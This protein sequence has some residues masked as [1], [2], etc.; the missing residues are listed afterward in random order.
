MTNWQ[1]LGATTLAVIS[2]VVAVLWPGHTVPVTVQDALVAVAGLLVALHVHVPKFL[3]QWA[4]NNTSTDASGLSP[5]ERIL[6]S[7]VRQARATGKS[8]G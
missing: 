1:S 4:V 3:T 5:T 2:A 8:G 7:R 6:I